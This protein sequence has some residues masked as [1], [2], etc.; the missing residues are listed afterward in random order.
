VTETLIFDVQGRRIVARHWG[1]PHGARVLALHG[2]LDNCD[3]F[4]VL[5]PLLPDLNIV[6]IDMAGHGE[7]DHRREPE[8]YNIL[9]DVPDLFAV[10]DQLGWQTFSLLGHSRGGIVSTVAA[11]TFPERIER[12]LLIEGIFP[13]PS[14]ADHAPSQLASAI[15]AIKKLATRPLKT[16]ESVE[17]AGLARQ[18]GVF[19]LGAEAALILARRGV[20]PVENGFQWRTDQNL[21]APSSYRL[22]REH[23]VAF[24]SNIKAPTH[25][26]LSEEGLVQRYQHLEEDMRLFPKVTV[27]YVSGGHHAHMEAPASEIAAL[28]TTFFN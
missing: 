26:I 10:A 15:E 27:H 25:L 2:W 23:I 22:S 3:S 9:D 17:A 13:E 7:S 20:R 28:L 24:V 16:F 8:P 1:N 11:G 18:R 21:L 5:A 12:L 6:A 4:S 14:A 19:P